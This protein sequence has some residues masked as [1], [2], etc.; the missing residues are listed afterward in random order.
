M[1]SIGVHGRRRVGSTQETKSRGDGV[2]RYRPEQNSEPRMGFME[3]SLSD[4]N[5]R[6]MSGSLSVGE[7]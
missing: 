4:A 2:V 3:R 7:R 1:T 5:R 6:V